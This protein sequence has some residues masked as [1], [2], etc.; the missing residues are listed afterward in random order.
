[1]SRPTRKSLSTL[2]MSRRGIPE[3][4]QESTINDFKTFD[5]ESLVEVKRYVTKYI[6]NL[7]DVFS[8]NL[9]LFL[10][11]SNGVGKTFIASIITKEAYRQRYTSKRCTFKEYIKEYTRLWKMKGAQEY[12]S[13]ESEFYRKLK[14][15]E[16]LALE[17]IGKETDNDLAPEVLEDL[18]RYREDNKLPTIICTNLS[19]KKV[20]E[21]YGNSIGDLIK[22]NFTPIKITGE[23]KREDF[24]SKREEKVFS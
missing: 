16:F 3:D 14:S 1:M 11:G 5:N 20:V 10:F 12:M 7:D 4:L 8:E 23:S 6:H 21:R 2:N 17:E 24:Y 19:P 15:V 18:L 13:A 22:G 9:G